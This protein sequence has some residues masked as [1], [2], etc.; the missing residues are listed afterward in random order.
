MGYAFMPLIAP[1]TTA[2]GME[3]EL[4]LRTGLLKHAFYALKLGMLATV[5]GAA[6]LTYGVWEHVDN[7][8]ITLWFSLI[9]LVSGWRFLVAHGYERR[10]DRHSVS[11]WELRFMI[12]IAMGEAFT[13]GG[14]TCSTFPV[15]FSRR[16]C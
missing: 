10:P 7:T 12:G 4:K 9:V 14:P 8:L 2:Y 15:T 16:R 6:A 11:G 3:D 13:A 1:H 5:I